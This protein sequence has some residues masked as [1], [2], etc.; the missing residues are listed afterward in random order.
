MLAPGTTI[1]AYEILGSIGAGAMGEVYRARDTRLGRVV[2]LKLLSNAVLPDQE[3][4]ARFRREAQ[5]L[6]SLNHPHIAAVYGLEEAGG[7]LA[8]ALE[9]V[10][11]EGLETRLARGPMPIDEIL[12]VA[13]QIAEGLEAAHERGIIHRD[14]KPA[15]VKLTADGSVKIL[16]FGLAKDQGSGIRGQGSAGNNDQGSGD[17]ADSD[18]ANTP[19]IASA[20]LLTAHGL[21]LGTGA[22]MAPEQARGKPVD[23]RAD[24]WAFGVLLY[25]MVAGRRP[26]DGETLSDT[27]AAVL[28]REPELGAIPASTPPAIRT[29]IARCLQRDVKLRLRDI[30]EAR[31]A[32]SAPPEI[33]APAVTVPA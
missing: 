20:S 29:L 13:R 28:T 12:T 1:G 21:I 3:R 23:K 22:Y 7:E 11:G 17:S 9:L 6:A 31:I 33:T 10:D 27:L 8:I 26:F 2:A 5:I 30:G 14:L 19:T 15:N 4:L 16:D 32:L 18:R 25:E 24:V